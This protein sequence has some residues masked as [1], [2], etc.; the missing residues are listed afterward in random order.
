VTNEPE[1][2]S[3]AT[4]TYCVPSRAGVACSMESSLPRSLIERLIVTNGE[5]AGVLSSS[6]LVDSGA[7][8]NFISQSV[9]MK[10]HL[11]VE[12]F[13]QALVVRMANG[14]QVECNLIVN[15]AVIK[16]GTHCG[17]HDLVV[18]PELDG[19]EVI[20]GRTFLKRARAVVA[21]ATDE[22]RF[23][24]LTKSKKKKKKLARKTGQSVTFSKLVAD[25]S[26]GMD[27][28]EQD[29]VLR[30][31]GLAAAPVSC[32]VV[33]T[34]VVVPSHVYETVMNAVQAYEKRMEPFIG[35]LP[36]SRGEFDHSITLVRD[37]VRPRVRRAIP[38]NDRHQKALAKELARLLEAGYIQVSRSEWASPVFFVP[39]NEVEDRMVCDLRGLNSV[40]VTNSASLPYMKELF[41][42]LKDCVIFSKLDLTSGY[43]QLRMRES[44]IPLTAFITPHGHFEWVVMPFGEKNAPASFAQFMS[45]LVLRD[46]VHSFVIVFQDDVL[47]ASKSDEEHSGH[48]E[49]VLQR[50]SE[51][52]LWIKPQKCE[53]AVRE[54][55]F[56]GHHIRATDAGTVI[57]PLQSKVDAV[58]AW[59]TPSTTAELRSFLGMANFYREFV[60][61][62]SS[63]AVSL[64][65]LTGQ[66]V[67]FAWTEIHQQAF[68]KLKLAM[69]DAPALLAVDDEKPFFVHCDASAF[70]VGAVLSQRDGRTGKLRP[71]GFF[72]RKLTDTQLRWDV[73]EREIYSVVAAFEHWD[74]HLKGTHVP[75]QVYT[76][77][78]SLENLKEQVLTPKQGRWFE[79]LCPFLYDVTWIPAAENAAADA[80]SRRP[81]HDEGSYH[82]RVAMTEVARRRHIESGSSLGPGPVLS[83]VELATLCPTAITRSS[84]SSMS[85]CDAR[86]QTD[87]QLKEVSVT[88]D[89]LSIS[90]SS[91][92]QQRAL[93]ELRLQAVA[94]TARDPVLFDRI[95]GAYVS[96]A[97]CVL[98]MEAPERH[99]Y[100]LVDGLLMRHGERGILIPEDHQLRLDILSEAHDVPVSG[101]MGI[102]KTCARI[103]ELFYWPGMAR[104]V[105]QY[106]ARCGSCQRNKHS[107]QLPA[108]LMKPLPIVGKGE[109]ITIDFVGE[110]P[111]SRHGKNAVMVVVDKM[112]KRA[113]YEACTTK[114]TARQAAEIIFRRVVREQGLPL[115][116]V[117][118]RD[119]RFTSNLWRDLWDLCGTKLGIATAYHQQTDG[120]SERQ[121]RTL[122][123]GM[124]SFVNMAGNDWD[125]RLVHAE[126]AY[127]TSRHA[128]TGFTPMRLHSGVTPNFPLSRRV[129]GSSRPGRSSAQNVL[130]QMACD[131]EAA[132]LV[133]KLAQ[134]RQK[135]AYDRRHRVVEYC[136][137]DWAFISTADTIH[138]GGGKVVWKPVFEGPYRVLEVSEDKLNVTLGIPK[139]KRHP[140]FH[141]SKL[142]KAVVPF[143]DDKLPN[144]SEKSQKL[145]V[146]EV[147]DHAQQG[148]N[149]GR[150]V[151]DGEV[152][153][154]IPR[155]SVTEHAQ[156]YVREDATIVYDQEM[157]V[158]LE[159]AA[160]GRI[161]QSDVHHENED[162]EILVESD[163]ESVVSTDDDED[164][165]EEEVS[166]QRRSGRQRYQPERFIHSG[167]LGDQLGLNKVSMFRS[168]VS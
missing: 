69:C 76:D 57:E 125:E 82:R 128:S 97:Q 25:V 162:E 6:F 16:V 87:E 100:R 136:V 45:Q 22:L 58:L 62:F 144:T 137:G 86:V 168:A 40:T 79:F 42:R 75:V 10:H 7:T 90:S 26:D 159:N 109:M 105:T 28:Y 67:A 66:R 116:I 84:V 117:S 5:I 107:N 31:L 151:N 51:H 72:S 55:D 73:Y 24:E 36:P 92:V 155:S 101:H 11:P 126:I 33:E 104:D 9:V 164:N 71:V 60:Q 35:K 50:L 133:L 56:L 96:D 18:L 132:Q 145:V 20:L 2:L 120:Q 37:D 139:S 59:P 143:N 27:T 124:R 83:P 64:T 118:D 70:A 61:D 121:V 148:V 17:A 161:G 152:S 3:S 106:V 103:A 160:Q 154:D 108:G 119:T 23:D 93:P 127:N 65:A 46:L 142:K 95:R 94:V 156:D 29:R 98:I 167:R 14:Q 34:R 112:S 150:D 113:Y 63:I 54:V 52:Q 163:V 21:H 130:R 110:L 85:Q 81:D 166:V 30:A 134:A 19:F 74:M 102:T 15:Q 138:R 1:R 146:T 68:E 41:A 111:K 39:K 131:I 114:T 38:L 43:H 89:V 49:Q 149:V 153:T 4:Q 91:E 123:E 165:Q 135:A 88:E 77:H 53:W 129:P 122:E 13:S 158:R 48:V 99:G 47:I 115:A 44:D 78:R 147:F 8:T 80:L 157:M 32:E 12:K 141:V 140:I